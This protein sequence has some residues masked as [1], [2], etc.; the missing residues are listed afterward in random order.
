[1]AKDVLLNQWIVHL[2]K[3]PYVNLDNEVQQIVYESKLAFF[4]IKRVQFIDTFCVC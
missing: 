2:T 4:C 3:Q 1:M